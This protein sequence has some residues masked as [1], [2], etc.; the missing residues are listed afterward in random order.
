ML[1]LLLCCSRIEPD[2]QR[3]KVLLH[4]KSCRKTANPKCSYDSSDTRAGIEVGCVV[5]CGV[6]LGCATSHQVLLLLV[7]GA[8][9][10][11]LR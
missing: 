1:C 6:C 5:V 7:V 3:P 4:G 9:A 8:Q 11:G 10:V 2:G